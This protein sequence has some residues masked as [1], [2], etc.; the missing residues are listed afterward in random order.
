[1]VEGL[2]LFYSSAMNR[3]RD[4]GLSQIGRWDQSTP[5][6]MTPLGSP[7]FRPVHEHGDGRGRRAAP[8]EEDE[9]GDREDPAQGGL[10]LARPRR[11][12]PVG[13]EGQRRDFRTSQVCFKF[14]Y[15]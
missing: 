7:W 11:R 5:E 2:S 6:K 10:H 4:F 15:L 12:P 14:I 13:S 1:M 8:R 9:E 3:D